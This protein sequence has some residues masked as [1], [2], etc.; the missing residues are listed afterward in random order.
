[1]LAELKDAVLAGLD[2]DGDLVVDNLIDPSSNES[3]ALNV[4]DPEL[5]TWLL[6]VR[7]SI[8]ILHRRPSAPSC[9]MENPVTGAA[10]GH[11]SLHASG[12]GIEGSR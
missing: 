9:P 4:E 3:D 8:H 6:E 11:E 5:Y 7:S 2:D 1:M 10:T 12:A